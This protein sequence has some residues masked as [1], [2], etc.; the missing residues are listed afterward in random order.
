MKKL[1][2]EPSG[3][4]VWEHRHDSVVNDLQ[5]RHM[6]KLLPCNEEECVKELHEL[7]HEVDPDDSS[8]PHT[9]TIG[10]GTAIDVLTDWKMRI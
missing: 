10:I 9:V 4:A 8:H 1:T 6:S 7:G 5:G 2:R 3:E